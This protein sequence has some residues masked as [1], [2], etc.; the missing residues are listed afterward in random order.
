M[1]SGGELYTA[2][3]AGFSP[4]KIHFHGNNKSKE[5]LEMALEHEIGCIVVDNFH[6]LE[7]CNRYARK[8]MFMSMFFY[9]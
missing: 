5:E 7:L 4:E 1:V 3:V 8:K 9:G 2:L 6:E